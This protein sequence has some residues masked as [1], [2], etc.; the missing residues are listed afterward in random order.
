LANGIE[1][2]LGDKKQMLERF[3]DDHLQL[4]IDQAIYD[5]G[6]IERVSARDLKDCGLPIG[7][8]ASL[9]PDKDKGMHFTLNPL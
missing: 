5:D 4:L 3:T 7:L 9:K 6:D 1:R 8:V 2:L